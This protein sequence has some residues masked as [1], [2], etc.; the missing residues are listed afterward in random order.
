MEWLSW[1]NGAYLAII[2]IG[3]Y[4]AIV[5]AKYRNV[6]KE[7]KEALEEYR[8]ATE[9]GEITDE[10]RDLIVRQCLD[11]LSAGV[12]IFWKW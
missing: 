11:V 9:D 4:M 10:E 1:S 3:G 12:K 7:T 8:K 5:S 2:L 6:L